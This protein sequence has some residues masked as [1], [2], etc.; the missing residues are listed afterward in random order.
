MN[1]LLSNPIFIIV[2]CIILGNLLG[3]IPMGHFKL[4]S[5][6]ILFSGLLM[7]YFLVSLGYDIQIPHALFTLSLMG[8][9]SSVG[10]KASRNIGRV[11][12]SHGLK[13]LL[14]GF[15]IPTVGATLTALSMLVFPRFEHAL[16][17]SYV[18]ALTSSPGLAAVMEH[19]VSDEARAA[20][21]LGYAIAYVPGIL[22]VIF[23]T[24]W[25]GKKNH[26]LNA[27]SI[28][29]SECEANETVPFTMEVYLIVLLVGMI[30]GQFQ[31]PLGTR[32][33]FSLGMTGGVLIS[34]LVLGGCFKTFRIEDSALDL[35]KSF[36]L[37]SFLAIVGLNYG[38]ESVMALKTS[39]LTLLAV[40]A[41]I[42]LGS[43]L[44]GHLLGRYVLK[45]NPP[46]LV[47]GICGGMTSTPGLAAA[48]DEFS[49]NQPVVG[50]G[51]TYPFALM[52]MIFW[53][54]ILS[55]FI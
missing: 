8:F 46:E 34:S 53:A 13:F 43:V 24:S 26:G 14:L 19:A 5:S 35:I 39:G 11:I 50:Y 55:S 23:Y 2:I 29:S 1:V 42:A 38:Y 9:I 22:A 36:S 37:A 45:L 3:K 31:V 48:L 12:K 21:G 15:F 6:G 41:F 44:L 16:L 54:Q 51:A 20:V 30:L 25:L 17:G 40:G 18:G 27:H 4:G 33:T 7:S 47:G 49:G 28:E 32:M 10:L 52:S